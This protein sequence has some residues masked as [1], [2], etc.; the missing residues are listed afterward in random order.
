MNKEIFKRHK[1]AL[2]F[3]VILVMAGIIYFVFDP[4]KTNLPFPKCPMKF[5][6]GY[7]CPSCGVQ[8][9]MHC[10]LH[11]EFLNA[12][13]YNYFMIF[14]IPLLILV[15]LASWYNFNHIFDRLYKLVCNKFV[16]F[17]YIVLYFAW[18]IIRN[19]YNI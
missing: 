3:P 16:L 11:G 14:S 13:H 6:T 17:T 7:D 19:I 4:T 1:M 10:L 12:L 18:W 9:A 15:I 8:R 5:I 2:L